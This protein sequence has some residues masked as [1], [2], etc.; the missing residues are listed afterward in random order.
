MN[1][2]CAIYI[3]VITHIIMQDTDCKYFI[4]YLTSRSC[5]GRRMLEKIQL[6]D[7][8]AVLWIEASSTYTH[9]NIPTMFSTHILSS[10]YSHL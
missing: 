4:L 10:K 1:M 5:S 6:Q 3:L 2:L 8:S 7:S 9:T